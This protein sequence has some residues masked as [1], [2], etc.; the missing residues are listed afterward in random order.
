[1]KEFDN[2]DALLQD[3][4]KNVMASVKQ[5]I[6]EE[7]IERDHVSTGNA[8]N[9]WV[10]SP[11]TNELYSEAESMFIL[12]FGRLPNQTP[13]KVED[14]ISWAI[15]KGYDKKTAYKIAPRIARKIGK[16]G[17]PPRHIVLNIAK[18]YGE[19]T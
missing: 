11:D 2:I 15:I 18:K 14:I 8:L 7:I 9:S 12:E 1:M 5:D 4:M 10:E 19:I 16:D 6:R 13:P 3:I 17:L